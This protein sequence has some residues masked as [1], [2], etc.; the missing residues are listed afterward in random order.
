[1]CFDTCSFLVFGTIHRT[2]FINTIHGAQRVEYAMWFA[3]N[4]VWFVGCAYIGVCVHVCLCGLS[5]QMPKAF[6][7]AWNSVGLG[8]VAT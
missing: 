4:Q 3:W 5:M 7:L 2:L 1:M 6:E 8:L